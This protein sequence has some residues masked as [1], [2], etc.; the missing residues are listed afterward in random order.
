M[1]AGHEK[2]PRKYIIR[3]GFK[4]ESSTIALLI[5]GALLVMYITEALPIAATSL[6]ACVAFAIFGVIP[7]SSAFAGFSND[8]VFL[9]AGMVVVGNTLFE[10]GVAK[11]IGG[12]IIS[13]VGSNERVFLAVL[14]LVSVPISAFLSNTATAAIML[15][16]AASAIS[17]SEGKFTKKNTFMMIGIASVAG[18][19]LTLVSSP[20]Q[21]IAQGILMDGGHETLGFFDITLIGVPILILLF[22]YALT[23]GYSL[24]K[25]V[26]DFPEVEDEAAAVAD[27]DAPEKPSVVKMCIAVAVL[28][29]CITG[30]ITGLWTVGIVAMVGALICIATGCISQKRVFQ[31]MDW[32]T[33]II[34][35]CSFGFA[36]GLSQ[37]G[38]GQLIAQ[39][40]I[41]IMGESVSPWLLCIVLAIVAVILGNFMSA[42]ATAALLIPIAALTAIELNYD[43]RSIVLAVAI[44]SNISYATPIS[45]PPLTMTLIGGYRFKDYLKIGGLFNVMA[46]ILA[47]ILFPLILNF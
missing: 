6:I 21:L 13:S 28:L 47:I 46:F 32:T 41:T 36:A 37:S 2:Q 33:I 40:A 25:K 9:M 12:F 44:V 7:L 45:T 23:I 5:I 18:G 27:D 17:M 38:A 26:F 29:F 35:G 31:K 34:F 11:V 42:T 10:T 19:G 16:L 39:G 30:F 3:G 4:L 14:L 1:I 8:I 22:I 20:P 15:P 24:Q 43:V